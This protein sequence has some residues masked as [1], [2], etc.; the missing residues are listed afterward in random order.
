MSER[1]LYQA[2]SSCEVEL[3][4]AEEKIAQ[5]TAEVERWKQIVAEAIILGGQ[6]IGDRKKVEAERDELRALVK[7]LVEEGNYDSEGDRLCVYCGCF[8]GP[9]YFDHP[10]HAHDCLGQAA[11]ETLTEEAS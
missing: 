6:I 1:G 10:H 3:A 2:Q 9:P 5:L 7:R 11:L 8:L 4:V